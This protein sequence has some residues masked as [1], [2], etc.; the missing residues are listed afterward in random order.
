MT[1]DTREGQI[2]FSCPV[3]QERFTVTAGCHTTYNET[4]VLSFEEYLVEEDA[5]AFSPGS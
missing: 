3:T 5:Q 1:E 4:F 2:L